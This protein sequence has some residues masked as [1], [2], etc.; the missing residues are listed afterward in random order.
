MLRL[1][2]FHLL[3]PQSLSEAL[4][5]MTTFAPAVK[6]VLLAGDV[7]L[8]VGETLGGVTV[9]LTVAILLSAIPSFASKVK[10]SEPVKLD[11]G[12]YV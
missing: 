9:M 3:A 10:L 6:T 12:V 4:A 1:P 2:E 8:T 7:M 5:A 11:V